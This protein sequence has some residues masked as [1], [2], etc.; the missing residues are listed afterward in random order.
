MYL[1]RVVIP[2]M[3]LGLSA[4]AFQAPAQTTQGGAAAVRS[5]KQIDNQYKLDQKRCDGMKGD[6]KD[7]CQQE[8]KAARDKAR[9]DAKAGKEK[10]EATHD[11]A[12]TRNDADYK[13]GKQKC[14]AMSGDAKDACLA[15]LK[16]RYGK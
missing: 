16:T 10:A 7:I 15:D 11:A 3:A 1:S 14:D 9:A 8:A 13:V 5:D 6:Q 2:A 12:K 4:L